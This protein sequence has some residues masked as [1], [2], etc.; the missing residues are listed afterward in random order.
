CFSWFLEIPSYFHKKFDFYMDKRVYNGGRNIIFFSIYLLHLNKHTVRKVGNL[1]QLRK[2]IPIEEDVELVM[3]NR[4]SGEKEK[5]SII[6]SDKRRLVE[7][8]IATNDITSFNKLNYE[9]F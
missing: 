9:Y 6:E 3:K 8:I 2:P 1:M 7:S 5:V 4:L